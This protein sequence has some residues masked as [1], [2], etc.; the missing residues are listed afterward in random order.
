MRNTPARHFPHFVSALVVV[1]VLAWAGAAAA[2]TGHGL[3]TPPIRDWNSLRI[4]LERGLCYGRCPAYRVI[5]HGD[6]RVI[7]EGKKF[8]TVTGRHISRIPRARAHQL[9]REFY[10][11]NFFAFRN[12]YRGR[13]TDMP[14]KRLTLAY[15]GHEKTV[16][17]YAGLR[18]GMPKT[19]MQLENLVDDVAH[20]E[21][22][23]GHKRP[24]QQP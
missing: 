24:S 6:G 23:T 10:A 7:Y 3:A 11:A 5:I 8:V 4:T 18:A 2:Q 14:T 16:E 13:I 21:R 17:D 1:L 19:I 22:W 15:D 20:T 9:F 12:S